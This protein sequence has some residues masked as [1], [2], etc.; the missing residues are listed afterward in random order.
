M[1]TSCR[2]K[3]RPR[4]SGIEVREGRV[5]RAE[6]AGGSSIKSSAELAARNNTACGTRAAPSREL[7]ERCRLRARSRAVGG[8]SH[9]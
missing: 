3:P 5:G 9:L 4:A 7:P 8:R 1:E 2:S 6:L